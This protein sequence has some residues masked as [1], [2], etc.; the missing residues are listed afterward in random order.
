M[1]DSD[2]TYIE[3]ILEKTTTKDTPLHQKAFGI[4]T[5]DNLLNPDLSDLA[6]EKKRIISFLNIYMVNFEI[7]SSYICS[8][9]F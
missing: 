8:I 1:P 3:R 7:N 5:C 4:I 2:V 9:F 6:G